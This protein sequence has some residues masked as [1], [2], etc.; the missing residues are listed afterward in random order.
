MIPMIPCTTGKS[1][2]CGLGERQF[3]G[4]K[5]VSGGEAAN[6]TL[7]ISASKFLSLKKNYFS[8]LVKIHRRDDGL[9]KLAF[10]AC[11]V[12]FRFL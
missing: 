8:C 10:L 1:K 2:E 4:K 12:I 7:K 9:N 3:P 6:S 11:L 5:R